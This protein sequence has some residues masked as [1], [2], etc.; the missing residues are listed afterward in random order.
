MQELNFIARTL[1][2][3]EEIAAGE[4]QQAFQNSSIKIEHREILFSASLDKPHLFQFN[5]VDD[6]F[7]QISSLSG[8]DHTRNSLNTLRITFSKIDPSFFISQ[9]DLFRSLPEKPIFTIVA[10][11]LGKR[12]YN[13]FEIEDIIGEEIGKKIKGRYQ[14]SKLGKDSPPDLTFRIHLWDNKGWFGLRIFD[15]PLHRRAYKITSRTG[16]LHP[17][18]AYSMARMAD[19]RKGNKVIDPF[20]GVGT[21]PIEVKK[22]RPKAS[23]FGLDIDEFQTRQAKEN[24]DNAG[25]EIEFLKSDA[26]QL[27]FSD[28]SIDRIVSNIPWNHQVGAAGNLRSGLLPFWVEMKRVVKGRWESGFT[29]S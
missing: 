12:N 5:S 26:G 23:V 22:I 4:I 17:P 27:P 28:G 9:I 21:I 10:S 11:F 24:A 16:S 15:L 18:L 7:F 14:S 19:I 29:Y 3:I 25:R 13:R 20:C 8:I 2:G 1:R 6:L